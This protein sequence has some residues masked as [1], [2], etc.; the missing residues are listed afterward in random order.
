MRETFVRQRADSPKSEAGER[1]IALGPRLADELW[2]HR[3]RT[4]FTGDGER[5]FV[6]PQRG[7]PFDVHRYAETLRLALANA[8]IDR[9]TA[10]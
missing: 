9:P 6:S 7:T 3:Q 2:Q 5:V 8:K 10:Q 4:A 1:T